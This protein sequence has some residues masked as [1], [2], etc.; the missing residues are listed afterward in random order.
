ML[1]NNTE[2]KHYM[3]TIKK[4][5]KAIFWAISIGIV[6]TCLLLGFLS[7]TMFNFVAYAG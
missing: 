7:Y 4:Y 6:C 3:K 2:I 1:N 5:T